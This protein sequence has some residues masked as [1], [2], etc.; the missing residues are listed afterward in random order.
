MNGKDDFIVLGVNQRKT[1]RSGGTFMI[2]IMLLCALMSANSYPYPMLWKI[3]CKKFFISV[4][5]GKRI[6]SDSKELTNYLYR[7]CYNNAL[8][9]IRN[10]Q[11]RDSILSSL[12]SEE[13]FEDEEMIY[14]LTVKRRPSGNPLFL[15]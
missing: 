10:N 14:A 6:F 5:E 12:P 4:W 9:Y 3:W 2:A 7:A 8:L 15:Y 11:I 13:D 1:R